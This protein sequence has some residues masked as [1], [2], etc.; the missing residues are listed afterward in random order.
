M[1]EHDIGKI[2][3]NMKKGILYFNKTKVS[4]IITNRLFFGCAELGESCSGLFT[5]CCSNYKC[6][7]TT[8]HC[9]SSSSG[10]T[11]LGDRNG[12]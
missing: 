10:G 9:V 6:H 2:L 8:K 4:Y 3:I 1:L 11:W 5:S 12:K 7:S